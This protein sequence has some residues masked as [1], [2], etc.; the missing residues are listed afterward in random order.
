MAKAFRFWVRCGV[1]YVRFLDEGKW[2]STGQNTLADAEAWAWARLD[3]TGRSGREVPLGQFAKDFFTPACRWLQRQ[4]AKGRTFTEQYLYDMRSRLENYVLPKFG[5]QA[6]QA[7]R[8]REIEDWLLGLRKAGSGAAV[9]P[10]TKNKILMV[11]R[12]VLDEAERCELI[13]KNPARKVSPFVQAENKRA[14]FTSDEIRTMFPL[15]NPALL[16]FIWQGPM[17]TAFFYI[18]TQTGLRPGEVAALQWQDWHPD[19]HGLVIRRAVDSYTRTLKSTKTGT[20]R[21]AVLTDVAEAML[22][23]W[24][25]LCPRGKPEGLIFSIDGR[26]LLVE[27]SAKHFRAAAARA[28]VDLAGRTQYSLRHTFNTDMLNRL[29]QEIVQRLMGHSTERMTRHYRNPKDEDM[30]RGVAGARSVLEDRLTDHV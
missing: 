2:I 4:Q 15:E 27:T 16:D 6:V 10:N 9:V 5:P 11:L 19:L 17:W 25:A 12:Y 28:G 1:Y 7:I 26:P 14:V 20:Q 18:L 23:N 21:P 29:P 13:S 8:P 22:N 3:Q 30:L 24:K